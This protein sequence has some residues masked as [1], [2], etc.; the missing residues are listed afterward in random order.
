MHSSYAP[1]ELLP[2]FKLLAIASAL[3]AAPID[4]HHNEGAHDHHNREL[5]REFTELSV[6]VC[7]RLCRQLV[8]IPSGYYRRHG[9]SDGYRSEENH[10]PDWWLLWCRHS[11]ILKR[12]V[13]NYNYPAG[14]GV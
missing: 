10:S 1:H 14:K 4:N 9:C 6:E 12:H 13:P 3:R 7:L 11:S 8:K 2:G 5:K